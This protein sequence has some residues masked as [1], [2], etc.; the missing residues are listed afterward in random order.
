MPKR[1]PLRV[2]FVCMGNICR[3]PTAHGVLRH[4]LRDA[5]WQQQVVVDSA[6]THDYHPGEPPDPRAQQHAR[7]RG[8]ELGDLRA[9]VLR[10]ADF[11]I[12]DLLLVMDEDNLA[13]AESRCPPQHRHKLRRLA[14][15]CRV[16]RSATVPDPYYAGGRAF[17]H[18][19]DLIE[20]A[21]DGLLEQLQ[22]ERVLP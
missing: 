18:A 7:A 16:H 8:Y 12:A 13:E 15:Y 14:S 10:D 6:G 9:R 2:T 19:L 5:G 22:S 17:E 11:E 21:C 4:K 20:D 1:T 3:S